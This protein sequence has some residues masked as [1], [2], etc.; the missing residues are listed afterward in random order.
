MDWL[1]NAYL[2]SGLNFWLNH[3]NV[4][5]DIFILQLQKNYHWLM[6]FAIKLTQNQTSL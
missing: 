3:R 1:K 2:M 6:Q 4:R 5:Q